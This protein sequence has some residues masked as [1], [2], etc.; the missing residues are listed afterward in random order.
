M[1]NTVTV[2]G[3]G[4]AG[5]AIAAR[6]R[7]RGVEVRPEGE[8]RL[9]CVPDRAIGEVA[10]SIEPGPWVAHVSGGTPLAALDPHIRRF[11]VHPLQT[12]VALARPGAARRRLGSRHRRGRR[13]ARPRALARR[14]ARAAPIPARRRPSCALPRR[15]RDRVELPRHAVSRLLEPLRRS[16]RAARGSDPAPRAND[17]ERVRADGADRPRRLG[18]GRPAPRRPAWLGLRGRLRR[19]RGDDTP[20]MVVRTI[21]ELDLPRHGVVGLVPTM[22]ALHAGHSALFRGGATRMRR[23]GRLVVRQPDA[24]LG[25]RR[26]RR[27][28]A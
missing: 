3:A 8:L 15:R 24:V 21:A 12:L 13:R 5:S 26:P 22:G 18:D 27:L 25:E 10:R 14:E 2:I 23:A 28:P 19:T 17:R 4:R 6:L 16:G 9:L 7:E 1:F 11:S 20:V